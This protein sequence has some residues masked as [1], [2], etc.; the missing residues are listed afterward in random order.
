MRPADFDV[1]N[2]SDDLN[3]TLGFTPEFSPLRSPHVPPDINNEENVFGENTPTPPRCRTPPKGALLNSQL[4]RMVVVLRRYGLNRHVPVFLEQEVSACA[5]SSCP[6]SI[7][8]ETE[9]NGKWTR[10]V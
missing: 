10:G 4:A 6:E 5:V 2:L 8:I 3:V 1:S 9:L 7:G